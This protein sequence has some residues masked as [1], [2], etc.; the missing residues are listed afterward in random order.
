MKE[1][2]WAEQTPGTPNEWAEL[3]AYTIN[4]NT[5]VVEYY[6]NVSKVIS[7]KSKF[8]ERLITVLL[9]LTISQAFSP[10]DKLIFEM[11]K[12]SWF[13][14]DHSFLRFGFKKY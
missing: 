11:Q 3:V 14:H 13:Q 9:R 10:A 2:L 4:G 1:L 6:T 5:V 7:A 8:M 12:S